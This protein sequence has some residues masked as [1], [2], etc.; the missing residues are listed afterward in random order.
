MGLS[1]GPWIVCGLLALLTL[2][3][4]WPV[5]QHEFLVYDDPG[6]VT[7]NPMVRAGLTWAGVKW[8][9]TTAHAGDWQPLTFLS[10]MLDCQLFGLDAG[11]HHLVNVL[12]HTLNAL[13]L[14]LLLLRLTGA[15]WRSGMVAALFAWHP[16]R[17][18]SVAWAAER[19]GVLC[20]FFGLLALAAYVRYAQKRERAKAASLDYG[21]ALFFFGLGL[22][23]KP[24]LVTL[25]FALLLLDY[26][27]LQRSSGSG[28]RVSRWYRLALEK[29]PFFALTAASC[30]VTFLAMQR[31]GSLAPLESHP[32]LFG[33]ENAVISYANYLIETVWAVNLTLIRLLPKQFPWEQ[34]AA[35]AALLGAISWLIW[36][37]R[38]QKPYLLTGWLWFLGMLVPVIGLVQQ[39]LQA[40]A[41]RYTYLPQIGVFIGV[42]FAVGDPAARRRLRPA[43]LIS[44]AALVLAG[45][46]IAT[47]RQLRFWRNSERL[48][49][50][51]L[52][53]NK[54]N[55]IADF[56]LGVALYERGRA[57][58]ALCC[59]QKALEIQPNYAEAHN[60]LAAAL[61]NRGQLKEAVA[62]LHRALEIQPRNAD[63][64]CNLG[65]A[66]LQMGQ[67]DEAIAH[68][69][70]ALE[71]EPNCAG[72]CNNLG[73]AFLRK[74]QLDA[75]IARF[76][77]ALKIDPGFIPAQKS[78][79]A[80]LLHRE[81]EVPTNATPEKTR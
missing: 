2:L 14:F 32:L 43:M 54:D 10:H 47:G 75:A 57:D 9:F 38:R 81:L 68:Y 42:T 51:A 39:G 50:H 34:A 17:V 22:M 31:S 45:S 5:R 13:L 35:A 25:P 3:A 8:A 64:Q 71:F 78:L 46:L 62:H 65:N 21:L 61:M 29:W 77:Q 60:N 49:G 80:A 59:F 44:L 53:V 40:M 1:R 58:E 52:A 48:F 74:G 56:N 72:A 12:L 27:P 11:K 73:V 30:V 26:W 66:L 4:Y 24:V 20:A 16:L 23:A 19:K 63:A 28:S 67:I 37:A 15:L 69:H 7:E 33:C 79:R 6:Y 36:R 41:D 76:Q 18:E 70:K 55:Y